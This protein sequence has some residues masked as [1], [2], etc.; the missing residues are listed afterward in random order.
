MTIF[1]LTLAFVFALV[2]A[3]AA[4]TDEIYRLTFSDPTNFDIMNR[5]SH[6]Q[7]KTILISNV[8]DAWDYTVFWNG[9]VGGKLRSR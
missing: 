3:A 2:T 7:P 1:K 8:T 6:K 4:Q 9:F 5:L